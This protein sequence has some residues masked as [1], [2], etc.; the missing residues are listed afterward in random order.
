MQLKSW[1][2]Y[3][4]LDDNDSRITLIIIFK[5]I[6]TCEAIITARPKAKEICMIDGPCPRVYGFI[7]PKHAMH[8]RKIRI[9]VPINSPRTAKNMFQILLSSVFFSP[10]TIT[11]ISVFNMSI[12]CVSTSCCVHRRNTKFLRY[13][14]NFGNLW[15]MVLV[16]R[17]NVRAFTRNHFR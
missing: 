3:W 16:E 5:M 17:V 4:Y 13:L 8:P 12:I 1:L 6:Y 15:I 9:A 2:T 14:L 10:E 7:L 11:D